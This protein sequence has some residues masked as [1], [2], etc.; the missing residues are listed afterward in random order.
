MTSAELSCLVLALGL[1]K[2]D[3][4]EIG[5]VTDRQARRWMT[6]ASPV[7][8]DVVEALALV[9]ADIKTLITANMANVEKRGGVIRT[10]RTTADLRAALPELAGRGLAAGAFVG[11]HQIAALAAQQS[12]EADLGIE[13]EIQFDR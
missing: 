9:N 6:G 4:A 13:A 2:A 8:A 7:P 3:L 5:G 11:P 10:Y 1:S 12:L